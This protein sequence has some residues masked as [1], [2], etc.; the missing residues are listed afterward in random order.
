MYINLGFGVFTDIFWGLYSGCERH[1][2]IYV[3]L[4]CPIFSAVVKATLKIWTAATRSGLF[5][6]PRRRSL[7]APPGYELRS[8][9]SKSVALSL[10]NHY[11]SVSCS[12]SSAPNWRPTPTS[13]PPHKKRQQKLWAIF[14]MRNGYSC[15]FDPLPAFHT[16]SCVESSKQKDG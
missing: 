15:A 12:I 16:F 14:S 3:L 10:T 4:R 1:T 11:L 7:R 6:R 13:P 8:G 2:R 5:I 9:T